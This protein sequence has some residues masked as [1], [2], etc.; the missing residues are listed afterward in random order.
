MYFRYEDNGYIIFGSRK[1]VQL[2]LRVPLSIASGY[3]KMLSPP[4]IILDTSCNPKMSFSCAVWVEPL[5]ERK[6]ICHTQPK[7]YLGM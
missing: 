6:G 7:L 5:K 4:L 2:I 3:R 1:E